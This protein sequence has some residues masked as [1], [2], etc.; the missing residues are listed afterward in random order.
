MKL[1]VYPLTS[2][3]RDHD[4]YRLDAIIAA[5]LELAQYG[6]QT[7]FDVPGCSSRPHSRDHNG[8]QRFDVDCDR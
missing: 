6:K 5:S 1:A 7:P 4:V 8:Y 3:R 2:G